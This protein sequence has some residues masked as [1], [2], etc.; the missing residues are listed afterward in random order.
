M[1]K[2][3]R[4]SAEILF[5]VDGSRDGTWAEVLALTEKHPGIIRGFRLRRNFGKATAPIVVTMDADLP[6]HPG[7]LPKLLAKLGEGADLVS[8]F[9]SDR[10]DPW[11]KRVPSKLFNAVVRACLGIALHDV[12]CGFKAYRSET[13]QN[14]HLYGE[15]HRFIPVLVVDLGYRIAEVPVRHHPRKFGRSKYGLSRLMRGFFN[16]L[17]VLAI[18]RYLQRPAHMFGTLALTTDLPS[19]LILAYVSA[20]WCPGMGPIGNRPLF[21]LGILLVLIGMQCVSLGL[22]GELIKQRTDVPHTDLFL[23]EMTG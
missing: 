10:K 12:H 7:E 17:T 15:I 2:R 16:L 1:R 3:H 6:N 23:A 18:T 5:V 20:L 19:L 9:K 14:L 8:G 11:T 21:F 13:L 22:A 4:A